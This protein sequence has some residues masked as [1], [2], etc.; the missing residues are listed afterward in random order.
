MLVIGDIADVV[1]LRGLLPTIVQI[2]MC[3]G[4]RKFARLL[5]HPNRVVDFAKLNPVE[6]VRRDDSILFYLSFPNSQVQQVFQSGNSQN[7]GIDER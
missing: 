2:M 5:S 3:A 4:S 6:R 7:G 1:K